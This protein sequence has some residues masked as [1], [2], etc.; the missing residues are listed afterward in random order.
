MTTLTTTKKTITINHISVK[1]Q[2]KLPDAIINFIDMAATATNRAT[3]YNKKGEQDE[4]VLKVHKDL[5]GIDRGIY[6]LCLMM[7]GI[8]DFAK[9]QGIGF[10]LDNP[11]GDAD[12][13]LTTEQEAKVLSYLTKFMEPQKLFKLYG[14][15]RVNRVNNSRTK[16]LMIR[17]ILTSPKLELWSVKYR[18]K[19]RRA[20]EH[21]WDKKTT[22]IIKAILAKKYGKTVWEDTSWNAKER[23]ILYRAI[24]KYVTT[25]L[26]EPNEV[27]ECVAFILG[28]EL[29]MTMRL[30]KAYVEAKTNLKK[31]KGI[32]KEQLFYLR[33]RYHKDLGKET[34]YEIAQTTMTN[35]QKMQTQKA[36]KKAGV[37]VEFDPKRADAVRLY[38]YAYEMGLDNKVKS[39]LD[40][41]ARAGANK[42]LVNYDRVGILVDAS[43][44]HRGDKTQALRPIAISLA[45]RDILV[46]ASEEA[47]VEYAG[48]Y[49]KDGLVR[50]SGDTSLAKPLVKLLKKDPEAVFVFSDG[51]ENAPAGRFAETV[52]HVRKMGIKT[53]IYHVAPVF[54]AEK[55][56]IKPL[57]DETQAL[58]LSSPDAIGSTMLR[59]MLQQDLER[60]IDSLARMTL[61]QLGY[62]LED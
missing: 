6:S 26:L 50:P 52:K 43:E 14:E 9:R 23:K 3:H 38:I 22:S 45:T 62:K 13:T 12:S 11:R 60:G 41:K 1:E 51:Y 47:F 10:L 36:A 57:S 20:L 7:P 56:G 37:K 25:S 18:V 32:P 53:P 28:H 46:S 21:A 54:A 17:S 5:F 30:H 48:G 59:P 19:L 29:N 27:Y 31:G 24:D 33:S 49:E 15:M 16:K 35:R 58:P 39:A 55:Q 42:L 61:P 34:V 4:A 44:S 40:D 2:K 8:T